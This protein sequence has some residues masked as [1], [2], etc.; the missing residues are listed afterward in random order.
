MAGIDI[1]ND[2]AFSSF[3]LVGALKKVAHVPGM[4]GQLPIFEDQPVRTTT[5]AIEQHDQTLTIVPTTPRGAPPRTLARDLRSIRDFRTVRIAQSDRISASQIQDIRAF[6]D[7]S[8]LDQVQ[9]EVM[10]VMTRLRNNMLATH[11]N[12]RLGAVQGIVYDSDGSTVIR[13][14]FTEFGITQATEIDFDLDNATPASGAVRIKCNQVTRAMMRA[15]KGAWVNGQSYVMALCGDTFFDQ[16]VAHSEVRETYKYQ[17]EAGLLRNTVGNAFG[18]VQYGDITFVN[19]R[20]TDDGTTMAITTTTAKFFP[21]N[22]PGAFKRALSPLESMDFVNTPGEE[23]Y[24][25]LIADD[26]R[27][28]WVDAELYSYPLFI[29]TRPEML[30]RARNT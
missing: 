12:M 8:E 20:G 4:L 6:G 17:A 18:A 21:V 7:T 3:E 9:D 22:A 30:Q 16:L 15:A 26:D 25:L 2:N 13:N 28:F 11:E 1:F 10:G 27:K 23:F 24:P 14:W 29:C 19:F 5:V